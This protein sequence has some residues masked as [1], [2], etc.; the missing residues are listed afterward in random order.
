M[1]VFD[2]VLFGLNMLNVAK[3][4]AVSRTTDMLELVR[5]PQFANR[6]P[7]QLSGGQQQRV[8]LARALAPKPKVLLLDESLSALD[9][10]LRKAMRV[11]LKQIQRETGIT[12]IFVTHDQDEALTMSDR[13]A[14][15]SEG[16][17]QQIGGAREIYETPVNRFVADFIGEV[18]LLPG[19]IE[20]IDDTKAHFVLAGNHPIVIKVSDMTREGDFIAI[21]PEKTRLSP[22]KDGDL[23]GVIERHIYIGAIT[24]THVRLHQGPLF[25]VRMQN[26]STDTEDLAPGSEAG[27]IIGAGAV[28]LLQK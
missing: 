27:I 10:N 8:A 2:N 12:F 13:I 9:L 19:K 14:V 3:E 23:R 16:A 20:K 1:T 7:A 26:I 15:M 6:F 11:E 24:E 5:L 25:I 21:R 22:V 4:Q 28:R 18:N 17:I